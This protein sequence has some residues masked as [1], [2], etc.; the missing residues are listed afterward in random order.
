M[1]R[2][3]DL[4]VGAEVEV[5]E[6]AVALLLASGDRVEVVLERG[7]EVVV[8]E[9]GEVLLEQPDDA[10]REPARNERLSALGDIAAVRG[11]RR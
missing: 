6:P 9:V 2:R 8:D 4:V 5:L 1:L 10:E 3:P 11:S 7:G